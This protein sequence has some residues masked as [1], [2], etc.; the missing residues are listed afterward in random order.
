MGMKPECLGSDGLLSEVGSPSEVSHSSF[1]QPCPR[2]HSHRG[3]WARQGK[4][5]GGAE[6][7]GPASRIQASGESFSCALLVLGKGM[8][9]LA[10]GSA[11]V[12]HFLSFTVSLICT[13]FPKNMS[14]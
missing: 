6:L 7:A 12:E 11:P 14:T 4:P 1:Q 3:P 2:S 9:L 10:H 5:P 13:Y 8:L